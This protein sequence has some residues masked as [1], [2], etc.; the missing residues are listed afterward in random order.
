MSFHSEL[1]IPEEKWMFHFLPGAARKKKYSQKTGTFLRAIYIGLSFFFNLRY[2]ASIFKIQLRKLPQI[3]TLRLFVTLIIH[4]RSP[5]L[6]LK[7]S[8]STRDSFLFLLS[9]LLA[10]MFPVH[11]QKLMV[12][13]YSSHQQREPQA[14]SHSCFLPIFPLLTLL[15]V[16]LCQ[17]MLYVNYN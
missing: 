17:P 14:N 5:S 13:F 4:L 9:I 16:A 7:S 10:I 1:S 12:H 15:I 11:N 3:P 6:H 2:R 8:V